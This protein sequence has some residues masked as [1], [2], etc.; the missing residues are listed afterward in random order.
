MDRNT[1]TYLPTYL[2]S[3]I[4]SFIFFS[5][6]SSKHEGVHNEFIQFLF[7]CCWI[8]FWNHIFAIVLISIKDAIKHIFLYFLTPGCVGRLDSSQRMR[9]TVKM[10]SKFQNQSL[11]RFLQICFMFLFDVRAFPG[12]ATLYFDHVCW[13]FLAANQEHWVVIVKLIQCDGFS[14]LDTLM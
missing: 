3:F 1:H 4:H 12:P 10:F 6:L 14:K 2:H 11:R 7:Q 9:N 13:F 5:G 8:R